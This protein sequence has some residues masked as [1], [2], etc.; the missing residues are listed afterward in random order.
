MEL[1]KTILYLSLSEAFNPWLQV[2]SMIRELGENP[3]AE[4]QGP[5]LIIDK[6]EKKERLVLHMKAVELEQ[7][8]VGLIEENTEIAL[9]KIT[10]VNEVSKIAE[11]KSV[12]HEA[13]YI[14]PFDLPF[15]EI[16]IC[17]KDRFLRAS[18]LVDVSTDVGIVFDQAEGD[19]VKHYE[20]GPMAKEQ[21]Q[22]IFLSWPRDD[23]PENFVFLSLKYEQTKAFAFEREYI[24][25]FLE[26]ANKWEAK[27]APRVFD[28]IRGKGD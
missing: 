9:N 28:Y 3:S 16:L 19:V 23:L 24:K 15:H 6:K 4:I 21:L 25:R 26:A 1:V 13:R 18:E 27:Q 5:P 17:I 7:E 20:F 2:R 14:E 10:K 11:V 22:S 12:W 8:G